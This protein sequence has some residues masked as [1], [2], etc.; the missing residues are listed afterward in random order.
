MN[1]YLWSNNTEYSYFEKLE[2]RTKLVVL[3]ILNMA[4][5]LQNAPANSTY[6][7]QCIIYHPS[8]SSSSSSPH[9]P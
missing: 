6:M 9:S 7:L 1:H 4:N 5:L 8:T 2:D 3:D